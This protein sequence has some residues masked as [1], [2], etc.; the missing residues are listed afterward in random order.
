MSL[1]LICN[2]VVDG[3]YDIH[4]SGRSRLLQ[5]HLPCHHSR[6]CIDFVVLGQAVNEKSCRETPSSWGQRERGVQVYAQYF[7]T[8]FGRVCK[9]RSVVWV[10]DRFG[11]VEDVETVSYFG[12]LYCLGC[13]AFV[14]TWWVWMLVV[15]LLGVR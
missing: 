2:L 15:L 11:A 9:V 12:M 4:I 6:G 3:R 13:K 5:S 14:L 7:L 1:G 10:W 8:K